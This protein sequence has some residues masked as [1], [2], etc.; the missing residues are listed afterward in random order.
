MIIT[1][2]F[3]GPRK[4]VPYMA[5]FPEEGVPLKEFLE[6]G[7]LYPVYKV[8]T[9]LRT[10]VF[11]E[12]LTKALALQWATK[13]VEAAKLDEIEA[14]KYALDLATHPTP[15]LLEWIRARR[16]LIALSRA[17]PHKLGSKGLSLA[18]LW[19][20]QACLSLNPV[21]SIYETLWCISWAL[22]YASRGQETAYWESLWENWAMELGEGINHLPSDETSH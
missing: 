17:T 16:D 7:D 5:D 22:F 14:I 19:G 3:L 6:L 4:G 12:S 13:A 10:N 11:P 15:T 18:K 21:G 1:R 8:R 2:E 9:A 20:I